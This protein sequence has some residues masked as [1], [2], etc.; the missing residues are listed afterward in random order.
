MN[1]ERKER[2]KKKLCII[3]MSIKSLAYININFLKKD[4]LTDLDNVFQRRQKSQD[5]I[6]HHSKSL[7]RVQQQVLDNLHQH[8]LEWTFQVQDTP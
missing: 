6:V 8:D 7:C 1:K 5:K 4:M 2:E 3:N